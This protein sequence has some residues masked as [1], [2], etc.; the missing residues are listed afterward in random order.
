MSVS[1]SCPLVQRFFLSGGGVILLL[2]WTAHG[3]N[4]VTG[5]AGERRRDVQMY[6]R[7][8]GNRGVHSES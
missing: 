7:H 6:G 8:V 3:L 1:F 5:C 2:V 4:G